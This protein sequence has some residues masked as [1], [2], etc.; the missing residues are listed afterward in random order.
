MVCLQL[1]KVKRGRMMIGWKAI[2]SFLIAVVL[3]GC[4]MQEELAETSALE[5]QLSPKIICADIEYKVDEQSIYWDN[6]MQ[7]PNVNIENIYR[8]INP[9]KAPD[10]NELLEKID[11]MEIQERM[12]FGNIFVPYLLTIDSLQMTESDFYE[13]F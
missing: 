8:E 4:S 7:K 5:L 12:E 10:F 1:E 6:N 9:T 3:S 11:N 2:M 13:L